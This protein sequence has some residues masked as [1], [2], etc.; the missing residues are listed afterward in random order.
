MPPKAKVALHRHTRISGNPAPRVRAANEDYREDFLI[1]FIRKRDAKPIL[2]LVMAFSTYLRKL[3]NKTK[4]RFTVR[5]FLREG[6][7]RNRSFVGWVAVYQKSVVG[8]LFGYR[9]YD[10]ENGARQFHIA[11]LY[12]GVDVRG[13]GI[14]RALMKTASLYARRERADK[15]LWE[16]YKPNNK[17][18]AFYLKLGAKKSKTLFLMSLH[19]KKLERLVRS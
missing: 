7:G 12:V 14:G 19:G 4:F 3:G 15:I 10:T 2:K 6:F 16:V 8:Y 17:A 5:A 9:G 13:R 11:D 18:K 1:R